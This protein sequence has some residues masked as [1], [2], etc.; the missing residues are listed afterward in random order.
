M[1]RPKSYAEFI[2]GTLAALLVD[3]AAEYPELTKELSRDLKRLHSAIDSHGIRFALDT[4]PDFRKH[5]DTCLGHRR[6]TSSHLI[7]FGSDKRG[8]TIPR[9]FR[10]LILR[11]FDRNGA[12]KHCP[13]SRAIFWIRQLLGAVRKLKLES[14]AKDQGNAVSGFLK[15]DQEVRDGCLSW[16]DHSSFDP[17]AAQDLSFKDLL[18]PLDSSVKFL[19]GLE[20]T[21]SN[22]P[23]GLLEKVQQVADLVSSQLGVFNPEDWRF[24][25]GPGAVSDQPFGSYRYD[26]KS[27]PDRLDRVFPWED[28]AFANYSQVPTLSLDSRRA[29]ELRKEFPARLLAVPKTLS[30]PRLIASEPTCLQWA[31]QCIKSY[32]YQRTRETFIRNFVDFT[33]QDRNGSLALAAS[34]CGSHAT[35]DL[36]EASDRVSLWHVERLFRRLPSLLDALQASRSAY[37]EQRVDR[38]LPRYSRIRKYST[39]GNATIFPV[40]SLFF[41]SLALGTLFYKRGL[42]VNFTNMRRIGRT[43][44]LVFGDDI[45]VP[46]DCSGLLVE[47]LHGLHLK[48]NA[49]KTFL[50]GNFRESCGVD[51]YGGTNVTSV[52]ILDVPRRAG[53]GSIVSSVDVHNNLAEAG[54]LHTAAYIRKTASRAVSN[55]IRF[56]KHGSGLFGWSDLL[57]TYPTCTRVRW[58]KYLQVREEQCLVLK[59][60]T[61]RFCPNEGS[62][63]LQYFTEAPRRVTSVVS[64]IGA[65]ER[66]PKVSLGLGWA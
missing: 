34:Q 15:T 9:L 36:S 50:E 19:P 56:V 62:V 6:L 57:G 16:A 7:H 10:G 14:S 60:K 22:L 48:V 17:R 12:L 47:L 13:D 54:L 44:V 61:K 18:A 40:Q 65:L 49:R 4:M 5:F 25:H 35:I 23:Y 28:F 20:P 46:D 63:L 51:A 59:T 2:R 43:A 38:F 42:T 8:G 52:S 11:V 53:P 58:N 27:W 24:R 55:K 45:I 39:M 41:M 21:D 37:I 31:Q 30:K 64:T 66:R 26:F 32:F 33:R 29:Q 1:L 3:C